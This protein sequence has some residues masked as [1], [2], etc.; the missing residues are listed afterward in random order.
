MA[1]C[2]DLS[3]RLVDRSGCGQGRC[4]EAGV[5]VMEALD[6]NHGY[7]AR[8]RR[9]RDLPQHVEQ[10]A[11]AGFVDEQLRLGVVSGPVAGEEVLVIAEALDAAQRDAADADPGQ[12]RLQRR[13]DLGLEDGDDVLECHVSLSNL[14]RPV[15]RAVR[16]GMRCGRASASRPAECR[17]ARLVRRSAR[18]AARGQIRKQQCRIA[19][20]G[21]AT[22]GG[23]STAASAR[24]GWARGAAGT[25]GYR[26][27]SRT[28]GTVGAG[29]PSA[30]CW[31][32]WQCAAQRL[33]CEGSRLGAPG[34]PSAPVTEVMP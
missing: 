16:G 27:A 13:D 34:M 10:R 31:P 23:S 14:R 33:G 5:Q 28:G 12:L 9:V 30:F 25:T 17:L 21:L 1:G 2:A 24:A 26:L 22:G 20:G 18:D 11:D 6:R 15:G 4:I 29:L 8:C 7:H 32:V 19:S 3:G